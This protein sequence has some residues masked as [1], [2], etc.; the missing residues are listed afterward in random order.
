MLLEQ[1]IADRIGSILW[2]PK[3]SAAPAGCW[4]PWTGSGSHL[5]RIP[6]PD[7]QLLYERVPASWRDGDDVLLPDAIDILP[8]SAHA[9]IA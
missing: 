4:Y 7:E 6:L 8:I 9:A 2:Y 5:A 1:Q 3:S